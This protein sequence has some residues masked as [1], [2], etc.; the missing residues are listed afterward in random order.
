LRIS[1]GVDHYLEACWSLLLITSFMLRNIGF[2]RFSITPDSLFAKNGVAGSQ[3]KSIPGGLDKP[4]LPATSSTTARQS[5][6]T[7]LSGASTVLCA[8]RDSAHT[9]C[10]RVL[11]KCITNTDHSRVASLVTASTAYYNFESTAKRRCDTRAQDSEFGSYR[12][13][14]KVK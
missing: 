7:I 4:K 9:I 10:T 6:F 8:A 13:K 5:L 14:E 1:V 11:W 12:S 2:Q 3:P